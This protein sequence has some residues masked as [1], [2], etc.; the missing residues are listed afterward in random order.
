MKIERIFSF[1]FPLLIVL[2]VV[3]IGAFYLFKKDLPRDFQDIQQEG[4]LRVVTEYNQ[5]GYYI[6][7][8]TIRGFQYDLI[9]AI[10]ALSGIPVEISL[11]MG[12]PESFEGLR[13]YKYDIVARTIPVTT[14]LKQDFAFTEHILLN[15]QVLVQRTEAANGGKEPI[16]NQLE[17]AGKT[18]YVPA[19]S[20][21]I[22]R[23]QNFQ[24]EIADSIYIVEEP[25]YS[26]EQLIIM[27]AAGEVDYAVC[28]MQLAAQYIN[29][30]P[31]IDIQTDIG[32]TQLESWALRKE[33]PVLLDSLNHWL[34]MLRSSGLYDVIYRKN[35]R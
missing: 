34:K 1:F 30:F 16:R 4:V 14:E 25:D 20:P 15:K 19:N 8:D 18:L 2:S 29:D 21:A 32:F 7:G 27:V 33:S 24:H 3:V 13:E 6:S 28:D 26:T 10:S 17:L 35:F 5:S 31:T 23:I 9:N 11:E 12:L 22:M